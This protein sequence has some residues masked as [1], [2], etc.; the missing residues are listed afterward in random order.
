MSNGFF[1]DLMDPPRDHRWMNVFASV[2]VEYSATFGG[3]VY[4]FDISIKLR[5]DTLSL[6]LV[7]TKEELEL[8]PGAYTSTLTAMVSAMDRQLRV[9][10]R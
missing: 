6:R 1:E 5:D 4:F 9:A 2:H 10:L 7:R 3:E 8:F